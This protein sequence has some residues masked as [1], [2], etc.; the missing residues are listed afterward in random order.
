MDNRKLLRAFA[1]VLVIGAS[2]A[3]VDRAAADEPST[4]CKTTSPIV[5][6]TSNGFSGGSLSVCA[7]QVGNVTGSFSSAGGG[8][9]Y[10]VYDGDSTNPG[11]LSGYAGIE[12][13]ASGLVRPVVSTCGDYSPGGGA[14]PA[15]STTT[16]TAPPVTAPTLPSTT[17]TAPATTTTTVPA[18]GEPSQSCPGGVPVAQQNGMGGSVTVCAPPG[19]V[20]G[21]GGTSGG[22]L[23]ADGNSTNPGPSS[24]YVGVE[25]DAGGAGVVFSPC[26]NYPA[27]NGAPLSP[28]AV[29]GLANPSATC[30]AAAPTT[31]T[32]TTTAPASQPS[33]PDAPGPDPRA[34]T[35]APVVVSAPS[36]QATVLGAVV[37]RPASRPR[38]SASAVAVAPDA[39]LPGDALG[40]APSDVAAGAPEAGAEP[41]VQRVELARRSDNDPGLLSVFALGA[42]VGAA[43][44]LAY[45]RR[46]ARA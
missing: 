45:V 8:S 4:A 16:I 33:A 9:G 6:G 18:A 24:G 22:Y 23:V 20:T 26:G 17:T 12:G 28:A 19:S 11:P 34:A 30:T 10:L 31:T 1:A 5:H 25:G 21:S 40:Q 41:P 38:R 43:V 29:T 35:P 32:T 36:V 44:S 27:G 2:V 42:V 7:P 46:R 39:N 15:C 14:A 13:S 37:E 3:W